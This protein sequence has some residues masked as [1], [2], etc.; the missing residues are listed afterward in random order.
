MDK[1]YEIQE[2]CF[3]ISEFAIES[4]LYEVSCFPSPGLVSPISTGAHKDMDYYTFIKSTAS[5]SKY[6]ILFAKAGYCMDKPEEIFKNIRKIGIDA[7]KAMLNKTEGINTHKGTI[8]LL[9]ISIAATTKVIFSKGSFS[10]IRDII[11][12]MTKGIVEKE[13]K[14]IDKNKKL[15]YG[16]KLYLDYGIEGIRGQVEKGLPLIFDYSLDIFKDTN[17]LSFN[18]RLVHTLIS[19]MCYLDDSNIL[20]R[21]SLKMLK[22][23]NNKAKDITKLGGMKTE[24]G[25]RLITDLD[26]EFIEKRISPGGCAD[27]LIITLFF[28][29]VENYFKEIGH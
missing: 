9:G 10:S 11:K 14:N 15:T 7:E 24:E 13:L 26:K 12:E 20:H 22:Y 8:F 18:D 5:L 21:H 25:R 1:L 17:K 29:L 19:I 27:L 6:M 2:C 4:M 3:K 28:N 16:E 23:I